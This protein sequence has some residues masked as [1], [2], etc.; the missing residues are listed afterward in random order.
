MMEFIQ[1]S[2]YCP[3]QR[4]YTMTLTNTAYQT[5]VAGGAG[6]QSLYS[7][8]RRDLDSLDVRKETFIFYPSSSI[9]TAD[10]AAA[11]FHYTGEGHV[12]KCFCCKLTVTRL[13]DGD[14][15]FTVH[16]S[17]APNC[18]FVRRTVTQGGISVPKP[19]RQ[20]DQ[21]DGFGRNSHSPLHSD[22]E[23]DGPKDDFVSRGMSKEDLATPAA[24][25]KPL[26]RRRH[27][28]PISKL[29]HLSSTVTARNL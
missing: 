15:P 14:D 7:Q 21:V 11:G 6:Y 12:I 22:V 26:S 8:E 1:S 2:A 25:A 17:R 16:R 5:S 9:S 19:D 20:E 10:I 24:T 29:F 27:I 4:A 23:E 13:K 28:G 3:T 18:P